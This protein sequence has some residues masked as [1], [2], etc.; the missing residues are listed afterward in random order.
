MGLSALLR[1]FCR[2]S[3]SSPWV[4]DARRLAG[5]VRIF[6]R[7]RSAPFN[8]QGPLADC[9]PSAAEPSAC[10]DSHIGPPRDGDLRTITE[11]SEI[12]NTFR[13]FRFESLQ[14]LRDP[15]V[16]PAMARP[17]ILQPLGSHLLA[18]FGH[19]RMTVDIT[20]ARTGERCGMSVAFE[21]ID[22]IPNY[23]LYVGGKW[24]RLTPVSRYPQ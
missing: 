1:N 17:R 20:S 5:K 14:G 9:L 24:V 15:P 6:N 22:G 23:N 8:A 12:G 2:F 21:L 10:K 11:I 18:R 7:A 3:R 13:E 4:P 19:R 16:A